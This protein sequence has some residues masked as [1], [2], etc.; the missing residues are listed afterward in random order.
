MHSEMADLTN[1]ES[2]AAM[3]FLYSF[4]DPEWE[5]RG[6]AAGA[7]F[8]PRPALA[9]A[10]PGIATTHEAAAS[11]AAAA[12]AA[13]A[14]SFMLSGTEG[15]LSQ[16]EQS[17]EQLYNVD[18]CLK[19]LDG[20]D[21]D[22]GKWTTNS[23]PSAPSAAPLT[24]HS[25]AAHEPAPGLPGLGWAGAPLGEFNSPDEFMQ[26]VQ[27]CSS[28][29]GGSLAQAARAAQAVAQVLQLQPGT[30]HSVSTDLDAWQQQQHGSSRHGTQ[31]KAGTS[32][33]STL[34]TTTAANMS[35]SMKRMREDWPAIC[36]DNTKA[37]AENVLV[38]TSKKKDEDKKEDVGMF[39][40][41]AL[42]NKVLKAVAVRYG[43]PLNEL[44]REM[45]DGNVLTTCAEPGCS[46]TCYNCF[47]CRHHSKK[48]A[49]EVDQIQ[50]MLNRAPS[51]YAP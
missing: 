37:W 22:Y 48:Y 5:S 21:A 33:Q 9:A 23:A 16:S 40:R 26:A 4:L 6:T 13:A 27:Q 3:A 34:P 38:F 12:A 41:F 20:F 7:Q 42:A 39:Y 45:G 36:A 43:L 28:A 19:C 25:T 49:T 32:T 35:S 51:P 44:Y 47:V 24:H 2:T 31:S 18:E 46:N 8:E 1:A 29:A 11:T 30:D 10:M 50:A 17:H 15:H 14:A